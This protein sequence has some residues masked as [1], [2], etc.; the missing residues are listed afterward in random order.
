MIESINFGEILKIC[1]KHEALPTNEPYKL[2]TCYDCSLIVRRE[3]SR[4]R[5]AEIKKVRLTDYDW[6]EKAQY[7]NTALI[8]KYR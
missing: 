6:D 8:E 1:R 5:R 7:I 4:K 3:Y 2:Y